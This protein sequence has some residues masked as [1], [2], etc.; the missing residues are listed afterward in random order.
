MKGCVLVIDD[1]PASARWILRKIHEESSLV[2]IVAEDLKQAASFVDDERLRIDA[3]ITDICFSPGTH[4]KE[5][6][7][8]DGIELLAYA[9]GIRPNILSYIVSIVA[10]D[11]R[12]RQKAEKLGVSISG[13][14]QKL[15]FEGQRKLSPWAAIEREVLGSVTDKK[16][17]GRF[18]YDIFLAYN[19]CDKNEV[20]RIAAELS[21]SG[22][23]PWL[24]KWNLAP[25]VM[26]QEEIERVIPL[27]KSI[28]V[29]IGEE[30]IGPWERLEIRAAISQ[31]VERG[32]PIIPILLSSSVES[33]NLPLFLQEFKWVRFNNSI[34]VAESIQKLIWGI[35]GNRD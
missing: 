2:A 12:E 4:D 26:F 29:C 16:E 24:D 22:I 14:Y 3:I 33:P 34:P 17:A 18:I 13:W 31:F 10:D 35:K 19:S 11:E 27:T 20:E 7:L 5:R 23:E 9:V 6:D 28:G 8:K 15:D 30:G 1:D 25:G 32:L 21:K